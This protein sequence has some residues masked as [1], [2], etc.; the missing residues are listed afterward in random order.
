LDWEKSIGNLLDDK[1]FIE[2][3]KDK[4]EKAQ[5]VISWPSNVGMI[6]K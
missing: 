1:A 4:K 5:S 2:H 6:P 3:I